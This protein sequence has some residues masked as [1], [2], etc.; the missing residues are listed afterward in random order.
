VVVDYTGNRL[1]NSPKYKFSLTADWPFDLGRWGIL[2]PRYDLAWTD[3]VFFDG[4]GG[5][6]S[7]DINGDPVNPA[8]ATGQ[9]AYALHSIRISYSDTA[10]TFELA[11]WIRNLT[12]QRFKTY[13]FDATFINK[14]VLN[15]VGEPRTLGVDLTVRF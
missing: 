1:P 9:P 4:S 3:D 7:L 5:F 14:V 12:D 11:F 10:S 2:T 15:F 8:F 6:G 13:S